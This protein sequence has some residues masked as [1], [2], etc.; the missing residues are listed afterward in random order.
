MNENGTPAAPGTSQT[1]EEL[2]RQANLGGWKTVLEDPCTSDWT[3]RWFLDG[4]V[5]AVR[6]GPGGMQLTAGPRFGEDAHHMVLWT[7]E[8]FSGDLR[9]EYD[10]TR[11]DFESRCVNILYVQA[12]GS[13]TAPWKTDIAEWSE[14]RRK[15][16]M[17]LYFNHMRLYH[18]SYAAFGNSNDD[19][20]DDYIRARRYAP[21]GTGLNGTDLE[22]DYFRTGLWAP[23]VPHHITVIKRA[24][25]ISMRVEN[26][27]QVRYCHWKD[28]ADAPIEAGRIGLRQMFT[29]SARYAD[30]RI[31]Q[32]GEA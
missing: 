26:P 2:F 29:R 28:P 16:S 22:P 24:G 5:A 18:I 32:P 14:L 11:L 15:P 20:G 13:G 25:E 30:F 10:Y 17:K 7:R 4:E 21:E 8:S 3:D 1:E 23:G 19:P 27:E 31:S 12:T 6:N 9:I